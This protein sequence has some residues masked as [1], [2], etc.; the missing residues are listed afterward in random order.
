MPDQLTQ[1][2][3][4]GDARLT[5]RNGE[6][7]NV[8]RLGGSTLP[9]PQASTPLEKIDSP[10]FRGRSKKPRSEVRK[11]SRESD[12]QHALEEA[13]ACRRLSRGPLPLAYTGHRPLPLRPPSS[14]L[15]ER[16]ALCQPGHTSRPGS[17][18]TEGLTGPNGGNHEDLMTRLG[19]S[20]SERRAGLP[21]R[22]RRNGISQLPTD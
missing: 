18:G 12:L 22:C 11:Y 13:I 5:V 1:D 21:A 16:G 9:E 14:E 19:H 4:T 8:Q 7:S 6:A 15:P 10:G 20:S 17:Q 3:P 2:R